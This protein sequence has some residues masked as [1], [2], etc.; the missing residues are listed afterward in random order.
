MSIPTAFLLHPAAELHDT[1]PGHPECSARIA[2]IASAVAALSLELGERVLPLSPGLADPAELLRVHP[3]ELVE[4]VR[5]AVETADSV[6]HPIEFA[7]ETI[8]SAESW[9][10]I[11]GS[12]AGAIEAVD[13]VIDG[14]WRN[15]FVATRPPGHHC[16]TAS[17][18]GFCPVNTVAVLA[19][20]L[21]ETGEAERVLVVDWDIHHGNGTQEIFFGDP[22]V[23]YLSLHQSPWYP[24]TGGAHE[25][26]EGAGRDATLN[27]P[28]P[29]GTDGSTFLA[30]LDA[31]LAR[32]RGRFEPDF[33]LV[34]SG[35]DALA[36]DPLGGFTLQPSDFH[37]ATR[38]LMRY[39][40]EVCAGRIV[41]L[42]EGGY[43]PVA[44]GRATA[45]VLRALAGIEEADPT[46]P[47]SSG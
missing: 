17:P 21:I 28:L 13:G 41:A 2:G 29:A 25:R 46:L 30:A 16:G 27:V 20:R 8:V 7:Q 19:R 26:G 33:V 15:A 47:S 38:I 44:T 37:A 14:R 36:T 12:L 10:A 11:L 23:F 6:G 40:E 4:G 5:L 1:G 31:A 45:A 35:F 9:E 24:G 3:P 34:S 43:D 32:V 39:A 18:M 42:L 22:T